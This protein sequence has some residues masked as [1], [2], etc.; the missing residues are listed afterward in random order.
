VPQSDKRADLRAAPAA[1]VRP[2]AARCHSRRD[3]DCDAPRLADGSHREHGAVCPSAIYP[4]RGD[5]GAALGRGSPQ[6]TNDGSPPDLS[7]DLVGARR[8]ADLNEEP[9]RFA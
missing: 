2:V 9:V 6:G 4:W 7:C 3:H 1:A 5:S 8:G